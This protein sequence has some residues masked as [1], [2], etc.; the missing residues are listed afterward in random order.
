MIAIDYSL[1]K[2]DYAHYFNYV[3]LEAPGRKKALILTWLK[4]F[5]VMSSFLIF[6]KLI[7]QPLNFDFYFFYSIA[8]IAAIYI[9][10]IFSLNNVYKKQ[11]FAFIQNPLNEH[12]FSDVNLLLSESGILAKGK[13]S[14]AKYNWEAIVKKAED[15][16]FYYLFLSSDQALLIPKRCLKKDTEREQLEDLFSKKVSFNAEVGHLVKD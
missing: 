1:T 6:I 10:P 14:E 11:I 15:N 5:A 7:E 9:G 4:R 3:V 12:V 13:Y 8:I 16:V 2:E